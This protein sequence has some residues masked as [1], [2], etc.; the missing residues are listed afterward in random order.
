MNFMGISNLQEWVWPTDEEKVDYIHACAQ[1]IEKPNPTFTPQTQFIKQW[2]IPILNKKN[3]QD[4]QIQGE[5]NQIF[6]DL[7]NIVN[8]GS[9][10]TKSGWALKENEKARQRGP[11]MHKELLRC[12]ELGEI[13]EN[14]IPKVSTITNWIS[15]FSC[16]WKEAMA[17]RS[18]EENLDSE[19]S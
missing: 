3:N 10:E 2:T 13:K 15:T 7:T 16:K 9:S 18:L 4:Q 11:Q 1:K 14:D 17:L 5:L 19:N 6:V 12:A 8:N